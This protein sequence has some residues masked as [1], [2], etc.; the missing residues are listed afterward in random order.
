MAI[1]KDQRDIIAKDIVDNGLSFAKAGKK[2]D[3]PTSTV[4]YYYR[5]Y[6]K[7][8]GIEP[9]SKDKIVSKIEKETDYDGLLALSKEELIDEIIKARVEAERAKKGYMVKG[10]GQEK[11]FITLKKQSLK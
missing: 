11:E 6:I 1:S 7:E 8:N 2:Y 9:K 5:C 4:A 10:G 3:I